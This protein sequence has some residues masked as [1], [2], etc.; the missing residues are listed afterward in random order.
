M[1]KG[2]HRAGKPLL[3]VISIRLLVALVVLRME[4]A[5]TAPFFMQKLCCPVPALT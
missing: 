3:I 2:W 4:A 5:R 1:G